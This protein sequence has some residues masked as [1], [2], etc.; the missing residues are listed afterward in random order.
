MDCIAVSWLCYNTS[1]CLARGH[2]DVEQK[3]SLCASPSTNVSAGLHS[4]PLAVLQL[5]KLVARRHANMNQGH[6]T[7]QET[8]I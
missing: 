7:I 2:T 4:G 5:L 1:H 8:R 6:V 3:A